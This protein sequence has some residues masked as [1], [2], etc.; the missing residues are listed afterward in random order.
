MNNTPNAGRMLLDCTLRDG[1]YVNN[2]EFDVRTVERVMDGL[3]DA[4]VRYI[5]LGIMGKGGESGKSTKF[6]DFEQIKRFIARRRPGCRYAVMLNQAEAGEFDIP[7]RT[8]Y[9]PD[10]IR[11]AFFKRERDAAM[12]KA[13]ELK[14][15]G[16]EV[17]L[18]SMATFMYSD[19]ELAELLDDVNRVGPAAFYLVDSF[20]TLYNADVRRLTD[21]VLE[22]LS[23]SVLFGFHAHNNIQMAYSNA[24]EFLS[25]E[26]DRPLIADGSVYGMG[27]GAG[28]VP[29]EL[30]MEYLNKFHGGSYGVVEVLTLFEEAIRPI[31]RRYYWGFSPEYLLTA[32]KDMNSVYSWY[33]MNH[34]V[35]EL[36]ELN[37]AL[38]SVPDEAR[39]TLDRSAA[40]AA[41][42]A[43]RAR[44]GVETGK[45][46]KH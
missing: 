30:L 7:R 12:D 9:T 25:T 28:N 32:R 14:V 38:D 15:K 3:Y 5:E 13:R 20:S 33:M 10:L 45:E 43:V 1:G 4:G 40:D 6:S 42:E 44:A 11:V 19:E 21:F 37:A 2:W 39:Y 31:F 35:T 8:R 24:M 26:T 46:E 27:R 23:E 17:F 16:Y 22:R 41:I 29:T 34:G 36:R 18:Q